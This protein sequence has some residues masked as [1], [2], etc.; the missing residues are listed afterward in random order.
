MVKWRECLL[1]RSFFRVFPFLAFG[2]FSVELG[3]ES[4]GRMIRGGRSYG[5]GQEDTFIIPVLLPLARS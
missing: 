3:E 4:G 1:L 5:P 2:V